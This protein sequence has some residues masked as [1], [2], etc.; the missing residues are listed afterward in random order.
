MSRWLKADYSINC[1]SGLHGFFEFIAAMMALVYP[2]G[3]P[4]MYAYL[5]YN[6]RKELNPGVGQAKLLN[7]EVVK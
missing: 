5:L 7:V 6:A 1:D 3:I 2:L 4:C